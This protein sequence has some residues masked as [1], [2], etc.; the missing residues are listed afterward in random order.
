[1]SQI[2]FKYYTE[3]VNGIWE[4]FSEG[5][6]QDT[7]RDSERSLA[8]SRGSRWLPYGRNA[9][10]EISGM[11]RSQQSECECRRGRAGNVPESIKNTCKGPVAEKILV[12]SADREQRAGWCPEVRA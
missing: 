4:Q 1:M 12:L 7:K 2:F 10:V 8:W 9:F 11:R 6:V 5:E 3:S